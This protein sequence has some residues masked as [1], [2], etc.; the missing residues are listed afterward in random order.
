M[1][2]GMTSCWAENMCFQIMIGCDVGKDF[3]VILSIKVQRSVTEAVVASRLI[4]PS[5]SILVD[6]LMFWMKCGVLEKFH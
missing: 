3:D 4:G 1:A 2:L 6:L 5:K